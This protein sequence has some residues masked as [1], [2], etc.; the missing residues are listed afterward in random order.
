MHVSERSGELHRIGSLERGDRETS[1]QLLPAPSFCTSP[2]RKGATYLLY[3]GKCRQESR[4]LV[5]ASHGAN[6]CA[7]SSRT[8]TSLPGTVD[9]EG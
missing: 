5:M 4:S 8:G 9:Q 3:K 2:I 7:V 6:C 1:C